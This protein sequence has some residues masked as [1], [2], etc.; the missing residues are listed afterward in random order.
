[1]Y[2]LKLLGILFVCLGIFFNC[3]KTDSES[4]SSDIENMQTKENE[5][6]DN[7]TKMDAP[8]RIIISQHKNADDSIIIDCFAEL[9]NPPDENMRTQIEATGVRIKTI[10]NQIITVSGNADAINELSKLDIVV[11]LQLSQKRTYN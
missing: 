5:T 11:Q 2:A 7:R 3:T 8:L 10:V 4:K 9:T 1:M 6:L